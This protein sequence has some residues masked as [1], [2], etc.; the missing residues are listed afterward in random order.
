MLQV[1]TFVFN[2]YAENTLIISTPAGEAAIIDPG[3]Y[4]ASE[5]MQLD[6][7]IEEQGLKPVL[8]LNTHGHIDHM[9]GNSYVVEKYQIPFWTHEIVIQELALAP[10]WGQGMGLSV[11]RS[12]DPDRRLKAGETFHLGEYE[13]KVLFVPGHSPGHIAFYHAAGQQLFS[14]DVLFQGSIGRFDL[15]GGD[16]ETLMRS[17]VEQLMTLEDEVRVYPGHGPETSIGAERQ[18]NPFVKEYLGRR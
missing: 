1:K 10:A 13:L 5:Q 15:P 17:I 14:G 2:P 11:S 4:S 12:P 6:A 16:F 9:L 18:L 7:Y 8:L 3:C